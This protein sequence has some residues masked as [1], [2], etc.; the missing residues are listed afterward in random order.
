MRYFQRARCF[1]QSEILSRVVVSSFIAVVVK[2]L[3]SFKTF[4]IL[5]V[6]FI[7][8]YNLQVN[9]MNTTEESSFSW[10]VD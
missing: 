10:I 1:Q 5:D 9:G 8:D 6:N 7:T 3:R 2:Q 4:R